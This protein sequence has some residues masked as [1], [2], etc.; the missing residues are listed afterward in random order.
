MSRYVITW[1]Q[2]ATPVHKGFWQALQ[3][4]CK[5][6][7]ATLAV[8][9][10]TYHNLNSVFSEQ[11]GQHDWW[12]GEV[13]PHLAPQRYKV[14]KNL[15]IYGNINVQPTAINP[16]TGFDAFVGASSAIFGHPK[17]QLRTIATDSRQS[18]VL[19]TT[20]ACTIPHYTRSA[21][22]AKG[23]F[24]HVTGAIVLEVDSDLFHCR[25]LN[26]CKD[27]SFIDLDTQYL[28]DRIRPA[29]RPLALVLG[30]IHAAQIDEQVLDASQDL[31]K[32]LRPRRL[33]VHDLLDFNVR[34]H[35]TIDNFKT[36]YKRRRGI[37]EDRVD[38]EL[39]HT[40]RLVDNLAPKDSKIVIV[41]SNHDEAFE[42]WLN[43]ADPRK[44]PHNARLF[45][46]TWAEI[47]H[48]YDTTGHWPSALEVVYRRHGKRKPQF[49][50]R[51]DTYMVGGV[52]LGFHGDKGANGS[53]PSMT[54]YANTGVKTV[55]GHAHS[56]EIKHGCYRVG[57]TGKLQQG[58][59][60]K[61]SSWLHT[62]CVV[63]ANGKRTL[64]S[65][66]EG[67]WRVPKGG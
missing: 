19:V 59:N 1:A 40:C 21:A 31:I 55:I 27:G 50:S 20:G 56:P 48:W 34:N 51:E 47:L 8:I 35:H 5:V 57:V 7:D 67:R 61:P 28:P 36:R 37:L 32:C 30:D 6:N 52:A 62:H 24:H 38:T 63:Y 60:Q 17:I 22:G 43:T 58:Y 54:S 29:S 13:Y 11:K 26:A 16:L 10:G 44:D 42:R 18:K 49:L 12:A 14:N 4:Y 33:V 65:I 23:A 3:R 2:N 39:K 45:Y 41:R 64:I 66:I 15:Q 46:S 25:H 9:P 53:N